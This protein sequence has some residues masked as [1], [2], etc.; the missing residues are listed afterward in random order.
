MSS[1]SKSRTKKQRESKPPRKE[2]KER[3]QG[4]IRQKVERFV[5]HEIELEE[6]QEQ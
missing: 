2:V 6:V 5:D 4:T 3:L 1:A